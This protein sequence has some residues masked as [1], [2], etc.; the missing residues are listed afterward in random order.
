M[1]ASVMYE[2]MRSKYGFDDG[3]LVPP[4]ADVYREVLIEAI[5]AALGPE[6]KVEAYAYDRP[7]CHNW[8][9]I[10]YRKVGAIPGEDGYCGEEP[11][12]EEIPDILN[13]ID[14]V[15]LLESVVS[16]RIKKKHTADKKI[17]E[18]AKAFRRA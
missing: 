18:W 11:E 2:E 4:G 13:S 9:L 15:G 12:P 6:R 17:A 14:E 1:L 10:L 5:N 8:C 7:G 3:E 16:S